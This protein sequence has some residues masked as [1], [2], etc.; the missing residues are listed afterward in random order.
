MIQY[1]TL[2][3]DILRI[4][5][6]T[7]KRITNE[8]L[9]VKGL[10]ISIPYRLIKKMGNQTWK[11]IILHIK[12]VKEGVKVGAYCLASGGKLVKVIGKMGRNLL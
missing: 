9:G 12:G 6:H 3:I 7:V 10:N 4:V 1:Q 11:R 5:C 8:I 2:Q